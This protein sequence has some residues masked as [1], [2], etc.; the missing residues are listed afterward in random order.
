MNHGSVL[1]KRLS[2]A[3]TLLG[4]SALTLALLAGIPYVLWWAVG[5]PWPELVS[6]WTEFA[7]RLAQPVSDPLLIDLLAMVGWICWAAFTYT[8]IR[9]AVW[10]A[11][12]L[13]QLVRDRRLHDEHLAG[14][15]VKRS[16]AALCVGTLV[17][18]LLG[19]CRPQPVGDTH[20]YALAGTVRAHTTATATVTSF[21]NPSLSP[22]VIE[23]STQAM[24]TTLR[25]AAT[26]RPLVAEEIEHV[27]Y[28]VVDG[29]TLWGIAHI[30]G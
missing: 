30:P 27:Q 16:L 2:A 5:T 20:P 28:T 15:S 3:V 9:E 4:A 19:V 18:A 11:T 6:S 24:V 14:L 26:A 17:L 7:D 8:L 22:A 1:R 12:H 21:P 23:P 13:P 25:S 10:Y 29:D